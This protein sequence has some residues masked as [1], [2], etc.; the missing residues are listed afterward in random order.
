[1]KKGGG[2][3]EFQLALGEDRAADAH[4]VVIGEVVEGMQL[5][6][7]LGKVPVNRKTL[8]DGY[9]NVGKVIGDSR[10]NLDV[11]CVCWTPFVSS[12][13][14]VGAWSLTVDTFSF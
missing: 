11:R 12:A 2:A 3:F 6:D 9:R 1:M 14:L 4:W 5:V 13:V 10:A 7:D 8:R